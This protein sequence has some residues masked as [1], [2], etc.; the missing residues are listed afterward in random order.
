[1]ITQWHDKSPD[2]ISR[3]GG[4][5]EGLPYPGL[6]RHLAPWQNYNLE[7]TLAPLRH[8][9]SH[10]SCVYNVVVIHDM[11]LVLIR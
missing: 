2:Q 7:H 6:K 4:S 9:I 8:L 10:P 5:P 1:M 3:Q 11:A